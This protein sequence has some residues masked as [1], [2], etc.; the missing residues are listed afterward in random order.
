M[1]PIPTPGLDLWAREL[2]K[3]SPEAS[4]IFRV[5]GPLTKLE[6]L[7]RDLTAATRGGKTAE[8]AAGE[9]IDHILERFHETHR[10]EFPEAIELARTV[11]RVHA[12]DPECP[13]GL[14][15]HLAV[16]ADDL[17]GHQL[18]EEN[19]LFPTMLAG[20]C[21]V[22]KFP[23]SRM[24]AEHDDVYEQLD[25]LA[26]LT[27]DFTP[28]QDACKTWR[29]LSQACRKLDRD[30]REHMRLENDVLFPHFL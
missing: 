11:E 24:M 8:R 17:E 25:R 15:D 10:R 21:G 14:A 28:P 6:K 20:S 13:R 27:R 5:R 22:L 7:E 26:A 2:V 19:I 4:D 3:R 1:I 23:I 30:L 29:A 16:M 18:K 12:G 9:L